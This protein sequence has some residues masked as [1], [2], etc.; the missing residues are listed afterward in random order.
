MGSFRK[1][2]P[3]ENRGA[4]RQERGKP[5]TGGVTPSPTPG[6]RVSNPV[7]SASPLQGEKGA[8][9]SPGLLGLL[10][11]KVSIEGLWMVSSV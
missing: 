11:Q 6:E 10:G 3:S 7:L 9:G 1:W 4:G 8:A 2:S 5:G